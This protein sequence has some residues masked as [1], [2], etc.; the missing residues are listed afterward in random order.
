MVRTRSSPGEAS[1]P[2]RADRK[3]PLQGRHVGRIVVKNGASATEYHVPRHQSLRGAVEGGQRGPHRNGD[4]GCE[5]ENGRG[6]N[7]KK[8][9]AAAKQCAAANNAL[10]GK[11]DLPTM[12]NC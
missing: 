7:E 8:I 6:S 9:N 5:H 11:V 12:L 2:S 1:L 4:A 10:V 3:H